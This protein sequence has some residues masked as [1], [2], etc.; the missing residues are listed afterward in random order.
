MID[1][2]CISPAVSPGTTL[3]GPQRAASDVPVARAAPGPPRAMPQ[4]MSPESCG[5]AVLLALTIATGA[6]ANPFVPY[7]DAQCRF[8]AESV[9]LTIDDERMT[10]SARYRFCRIAN[11]ATDSFMFPFL[12][13]SSLGEPRLLYATVRYNAGAERK[14]E[15]QMEPRLWRW[16]LGWGDADSCEVRIE[17]WQ[18]LS[19][20]RAGYLLTSCRSWRAPLV[21]AEFEIRIPS[22]SPEPTLSIPLERARAFLGPQRYRGEFRNWMPLEDLIVTW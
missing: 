3:A 4:V 12:S 17:Y 14:L 21:Y 11:Q 5:I 9:R 2:R 7:E 18:H 10:V 22:S 20:R 1:D 15:I 19:S 6:T 16:R 13:D 8:T